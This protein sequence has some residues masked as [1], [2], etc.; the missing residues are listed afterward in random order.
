M[1]FTVTQSEPVEQRGPV[2]R[3]ARHPAGAQG[4]GRARKHSRP[5]LQAAPWQTQGPRAAW[6][7]PEALRSSA[8]Q[9]QR[10]AAGPRPLLAPVL[11]KRV[12]QVMEEVERSRPGDEAPSGHDRQLRR[13]APCGRCGQPLPPQERVAV[14]GFAGWQRPE[15]HQEEDG[16]P[17][18][19][20]LWGRFAGPRGPVR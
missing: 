16:Q 19:R 10:A 1:T 4:R 12:S 14:L 15:G 13:A 20:G 5:F 2:F 3:K 11:K 6:L 17:R 7:L 9:L 8:A 18:R